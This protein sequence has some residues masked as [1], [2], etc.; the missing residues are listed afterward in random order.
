MSDY[1]KNITFISKDEAAI[2]MKEEYGEDFIDDIGLRVISM[3][4]MFFM[5]QLQLMQERLVLDSH[6][7]CENN[8]LR[9]MKASE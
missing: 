8:L 9:F 1:I 6:S 2:F 7:Y 3:V 4:V 5:H